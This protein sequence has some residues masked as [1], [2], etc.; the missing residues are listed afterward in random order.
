MTYQPGQTIA[1]KYQIEKQI[2]QGA[3][4]VVYLVTHLKLNAPRALKVLRRDAPGIGST[5]FHDCRARF[6]QESQLGARLDHPHIIRIHDF[7]ESEGEL[8]LAME[9]APGGSLQRLLAK[10]RQEGQLLPVERAVHIGREV[11]EG[12]AA[13]HAID[14]IHRDLKP[15][16]ILFDAQGRAKI[17]DLGLA[18]V[19]HGPSMRSQLSQPMPHP[20]TPAY[21]SPE[22]EN[23]GAYLTPPSDVYTLGIILFEMLTGRNYK[24]QMPGTRLRQLRPD[25]PAWLDGLLG[26][27][28]AKDAEKRPWDGEKTAKALQQGA[29]KR[30]ATWWKWWYALAGAVVVLFVGVMV[31]VAPGIW[32]NI[33]LSEPSPTVA[34]EQVSKPLTEMVSTT[35]IINSPT[36]P[37]TQVVS[38]THTPTPTITFNMINSTPTKMLTPTPTLMLKPKPTIGSTQISPKDGMAMVYVPEGAF[39]MGSKTM[40]SGYPDEKPIHTVYLD[41]FWIDQTEV[42]NAMYADC[43][44]DGSCKNMADYMDETGKKGHPVVGVDWYNAHAYCEWAGRRLPS[45]AEWEK[46]ARGT[47]GRTYPWGE[48]ISCSLANYKP[49][50]YCVGDTSAVGSY[51][52][53]ASPFGALDMA[54]NVREWVQDWYDSDYYN[55]SPSSNP[56]GPSSG[57]S[58]VLRGGSWDINSWVMRLALRYWYVPTFAEDYLGFR[59]ATSTAP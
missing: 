29:K 26:K 8:V 37:Q 11:A 50:N 58:R 16:N 32:G 47:D 46:A 56:T 9:Y 44:A 54:G 2:G 31:A 45:E 57:D 15:S 48:G 10:T 1:G 51:P 20:G 27:M 18:Q 21:M 23:S 6:E 17:A 3:F 25:A 4:G 34:A 14:V 7:E 53:G 36:S 12:L 43:V 30:T 13:M 19:P 40:S 39:E 41:A 49:E 33:G 35:E 52:N 59:C 28:L 55:N 5:L 42:T 24:G 38:A 22:Q